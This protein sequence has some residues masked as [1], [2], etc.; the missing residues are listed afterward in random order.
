M[1]D[2]PDYYP[3]HDEVWARTV[4]SLDRLPHAMLISGTEGTGKF[5]FASRLGMALLCDGQEPDL[6]CG[7][8]RS[9][10]FFGA[11]TH[12]DLHVLTSEEKLQIL[13]ST[14][15][16]YAERYLEDVRARSRRKTPRTSIVIAQIRTLIETANSKPHISNNKVFLVDPIDAM[17]NSAANSLLKVLEEPPPNTYLILITENDQHL[18]PT[19]SSRCQKLVMSDPDRETSRKW[20]AD[21][22]IDAKIINAILESGKG[23]LVGLRRVKNEEILKSSEFINQ[24]LQQLKGKRSHDMFGLVESGLTLGEVEPLDE[25]HLLVSRFIE[26]FVAGPQSGTSEFGDTVKGTDVRKLFSIYD[27]LAFLRN[28]LRIGGIDK[29]LAI[30]DA[31]LALE[32]SIDRNR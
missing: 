9:C 24:V 7:Q 1:T 3:W 26:E 31:L 8:C 10:R 11:A 18:L 15:V 5:K 22:K 4:D 21:Q 27:H 14:M 13:D 25:L 6:P 30:E 20:L 17:T 29:T 23:P 19:I 16:S 12:P 28:E 32:S 2:I